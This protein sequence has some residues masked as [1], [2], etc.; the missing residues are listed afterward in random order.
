[1]EI[2]FR[3]SLKI[4]LP[5]FFAQGYIGRRGDAIMTNED[6]AVQRAKEI[7]EERQDEKIAQEHAIKRQDFI[8]AQAPLF[9]NRVKDALQKEVSEFNSAMSE[10]DMMYDAD[11][12][13]VTI[14]NT[15]NS[16]TQNVRFDENSG[17][18]QVYGVGSDLAYSVNVTDRLQELQF[19]AN[20]VPH[21]PQ[22]I[23]KSAVQQYSKAIH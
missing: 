21:S 23:A 1:V 4:N 3:F 9:W 5:K 11:P 14:R 18:I 6:W 12:C 7:K 15:Q 2:K 8:K 10:T 13:Q 20:G 19:V 16:A 22:D 17:Q